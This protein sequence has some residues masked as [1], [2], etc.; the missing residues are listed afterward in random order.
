MGYLKPYRQLPTV[1]PA[2]SELRTGSYL[3]LVLMGYLNAYAWLVAFL[4]KAR[5]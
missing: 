5:L 3:R 2:R 4:H 1:P